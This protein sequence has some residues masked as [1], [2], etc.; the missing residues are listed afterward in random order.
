MENSIKKYF[1]YFE[2]TEYYEVRKNNLD[3]IISIEFNSKV[4]AKGRTVKIK[5]ENEKGKINILIHFIWSK[6][7]FYKEKVW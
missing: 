6:F 4:K 1:L 3:Y 2:E 7:Y 5:N